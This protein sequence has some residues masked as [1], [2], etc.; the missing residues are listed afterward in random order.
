MKKTLLKS[1]SMLLVLVC[2]LSTL[3][4]FPSAKA[5]EIEPRFT[6]I[7]SLAASLDISSSGCASCYGRVTPY[8]GYKVT[9]EVELQ[10]DGKTIKS[11]SDT[12]KDTF[13]IDEI[14]YVTPGHDYQV[15]VTATVYNSSG[16]IVETPT[17]DSAVVSY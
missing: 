5:A 7:A 12:N 10:R 13:S 8:S 17:T 4:I 16:R 9:L 14:Y 6:G 2:V 11:W 3:S 1:A 15:V